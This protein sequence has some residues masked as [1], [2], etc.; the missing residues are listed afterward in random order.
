MGDRIHFRYGGKL[1]LGFVRLEASVHSISVPLKD[2]IRTLEE[3][4]GEREEEQ[5]E[6]G[7]K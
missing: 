7:I 2:Q 3:R 1:G 6:E 4:K 5:E